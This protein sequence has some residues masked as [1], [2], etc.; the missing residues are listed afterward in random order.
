M[1]IDL[2]CHTLEVKKGDN[3]R[4][5]N[6]SDFV[7]AI[8]SAGVGIVAIT[9]HN[10]FDI[11]QYNAFVKS[12]VGQFLI[13]PGVELDV[14]GRHSGSK[15]HGHVIVV[16]DPLKADS[17]SSIISSL[18]VGDLE[19]FVVDVDKLPTLFLPLGRCLFACH[20]HKSPDCFRGH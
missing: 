20:Y 3:G 10:K 13:W 17:F 4:N 2:H 19:K 1:K 12:A 7:K 5:V 14:E 18:C 8:S 6:S 11:Q 16:C 9:N 15:Q